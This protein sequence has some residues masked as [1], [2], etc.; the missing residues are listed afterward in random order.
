VSD[1][2]ADVLAA[3]T[4]VDGRYRISRRL[5]AGGM[6]TVYLA[7][8]VKIGRAV[9][10]K[11]LHP[12]FAKQPDFVK[13][14]ER[15]AMA[16]SR[17]Y[18]RHSVSIIDYGVHEES[19]Y[20]VME[21]VPGRSLA[22]IIH[23]GALPP[24]RAVAIMQQVLSTLAYFHHRHVLHRDLK[25]ENI[26]IAGDEDEDEYVKL[27]DFGMAKLLAG[28]GADISVSAKG[29]V[30]GTASAMSPEQIRE[31]PLDARTDLYSAG[32]LLYHMLVGRRPFMDED[33]IAV[34]KMHLEKPVTPPSEILGTRAISRELDAVVLKALEKDRERRASTAPGLLVPAERPRPGWLWVAVAVSGWAAAAALAVRFILQ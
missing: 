11:F 29:I 28:V 1:D 9:A 7:E 8:R 12:S 26:M 32:I 33:M 34:M 5:G 3:D 10:I 27:L 16:M 31:M 15:E 14:F 19:P 6:G 25:A 23:D 18:H 2:P 22:R 17:V 20:L 13:R 4:L 24:R 30:V 21:Y